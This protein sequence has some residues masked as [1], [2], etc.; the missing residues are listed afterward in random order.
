[1]PLNHPQTTIKTPGVFFPFAAPLQVG[2]VRLFQV[3]FEE[4]QT[5]SAV[6]AKWNGFQWSTVPRNA[7]AKDVVGGMGLFG[8]L[9]K[10]CFL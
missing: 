1:M 8:R 3:G 5:V 2:C 6:V 4:M 7:R 9:E 10:G